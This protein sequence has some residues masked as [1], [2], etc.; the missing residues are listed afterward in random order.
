MDKILHIT[1]NDLDGAGCG[2][3]VKKIYSNAE[4]RN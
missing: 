4:I 3:I 1:H 2:I